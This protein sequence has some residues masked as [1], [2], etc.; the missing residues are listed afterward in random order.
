M[1]RTARAQAATADRNAAAARAK[2]R[3]SG[4]NKGVDG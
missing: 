2:D 1:I 3:A 4:T